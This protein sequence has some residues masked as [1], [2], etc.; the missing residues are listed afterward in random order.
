MRGYYFRKEAVAFS[1]TMRKIILNTVFAALFALSSRYCVITGGRASGKSFALAVYLLNKTFKEGEVILF[2]R[3]TMV[4]AEISIIPEFWE[5]VELLGYEGVFKKTKNEIINLKTGSRIIFRGL[6]TSSG[7]QTANLK[8]ITG[9]TCWVMDEAE[10]LVDEKVFDTIDNSIR[11]LGAKNEVI[12]VLNP[13]NI[14]HFVFDKFYKRYG[15][16]NVWSGVKE[17]CTW[18]HCSYLDN[19]KNINES[20]IDTADKVKTTD[21]DKYCHVYMGQF[22]ELSEG[23]IYTNWCKVDEIP[24][25]L[26]NWYGLDFG[27]TNDPTAIVNISIDRHHLR[28]Y[29]REICYQKGLSNSDISRIIAQ[30]YRNRHTELYNDG[31]NRVYIENE[32][33]FVGSEVLNLVEACSDKLLLIK[34]LQNVVPQMEVKDYIQRIE[35]VQK[36]FVPVYCDAAEPK[37]IQELRLYGISAYPCIKGQGSVVSQ[38]EFV[39]NFEVFYTA[40][41]SNLGHETQNYKWLPQ[42]KNQQVL[43]NEPQAGND[44]AMDA[45][46]YGTYTHLVKQYETFTNIQKT[47]VGA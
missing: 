37:S 32:Q 33:V 15:L 23:C 6:K 42:K 30:D 25:G 31:Q 10:E 9:L 43:T 16:G 20:F 1:N 2:T 36:V 18:I 4:S 47:A 8:S 40:N 44:H 28:L 7:M 14:H 26:E 13:T 12:I 19:L 39:K 46:R 3:F 21:P 5:K 17:D 29:L 27:Y 35:A 24:S 45:V 22:N 38:I 41:S 34:A 11:S